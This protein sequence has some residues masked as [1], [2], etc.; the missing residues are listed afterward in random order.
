MKVGVNEAAELKALAEEKGIPFA[1]LL[2]TYVLEDLLLR[3]GESSYEE[4]LW[5]QSHRMLG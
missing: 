5:L 1:N 3:I 2:W 4:Y